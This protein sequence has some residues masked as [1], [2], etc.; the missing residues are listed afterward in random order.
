MAGQVGVPLVPV[1]AVQVRLQRG[2]A[3]GDTAGS[4]SASPEQLARTAGSRYA[5]GRRQ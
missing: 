5:S 3:A 4:A 2:D 1:A